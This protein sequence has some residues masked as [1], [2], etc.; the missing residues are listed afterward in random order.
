[1]PKIL[2]RQT[3]L[4]NFLK[5][6]NVANLILFFLIAAFGVWL[7]SF[8][9]TLPPSPSFSLSSIS[10]PVYETGTRKE[11]VKLE[12]KA[13]YVFDVLNNESIF[14]LNADSQLPLASLT[15]IMTAIVAVEN[16]PSYLLVSIPKEAILMDGDNGFIADENM[17][18][19]N[20]AEAMLI[21]SS[22]DAAYAFALE[23]KKDFDID[24]IFLMNQKAQTL[25]L[26]QTYF[27]NSSGLDFSK[28]AAGAY[29]SAKDIATLLLYAVK[30][31]PSLMEVTRMEKI[32][33]ESRELKNTNLII[34]E[35]PGL[36]AGKTGYSN[37]AGG[38]LAIIA[39]K[40]YGHPIIIVVLGST[41]DGRFNDV[42]TLYNLIP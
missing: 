38:N 14:E 5:Q 42:K 35:I 23:F 36:I 41:F 26:G 24:L 37:L 20:L 12:A 16:L 11:N 30:N 34:N 29:G 25:K 9:P 40:G 21:S 39:D 7:F 2:N 3:N 28:N 19:I 17:L 10:A 27:L 22:N 4:K 8:S 6:F 33:I 32:N 13:A 15:K 18:V 31:H 1:M